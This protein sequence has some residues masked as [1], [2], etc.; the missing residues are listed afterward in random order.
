MN[1]HADY[2]TYLREE[3]AFLSLFPDLGFK[4]SLPIKNLDDGLSPFD[5]IIVK[6]VFNCGCYIIEPKMTD[7]II[8]NKFA[9]FSDFINE[10]M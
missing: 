1:I 6:N 2:K 7:F 10:F 3:E 8:R 5:H 9:G 4:V